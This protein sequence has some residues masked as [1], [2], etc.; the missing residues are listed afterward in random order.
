VLANK[1]ATKPIAAPTGKLFFFDMSQ[2][3]FNDPS[4]MLECLNDFALC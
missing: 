1:L 3:P 4:P 2:L